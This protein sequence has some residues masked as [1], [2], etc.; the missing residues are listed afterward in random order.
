MADN[1]RT[2]FPG[3]EDLARIVVEEDAEG[4]GTLHLLH[5]PGE[6]LKRVMAALVIIIQQVSQYLGIG[7]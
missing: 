2:V 4:I 6:R 3:R 1:Q 5:N 7:F